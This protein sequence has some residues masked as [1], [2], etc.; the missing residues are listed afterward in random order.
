MD[1]RLADTIRNLLNRTT[2][3]GCTEAEVTEASEAV[4]RLLLKY[5]L[6]LGDLPQEEKEV[7]VRSFK[8]NSDKQFFFHMLI[9]ASRLCYCSAF[10]FDGDRSKG[11]LV[12]NKL[13]C[14]AAWELY[15]FYEKALFTKYAE[16]QKWWGLSMSIDNFGEGFAQ[17]I[18]QRA[19][20]HLA[21]VAQEQGGASTAIVR[22]NEKEAFEALEQEGVSVGGEYKATPTQ[23]ESWS[24]QLGTDAGRSIPLGLNKPIS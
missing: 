20:T 16:Y 8:L 11:T 19:L 7:I 9:A 3:R 4:Q 17:R 2:E 13:S 21:V 15:Q 12:G 23:K 22:A 6:S 5:N 14:D 24:F 10:I 1:P 18:V